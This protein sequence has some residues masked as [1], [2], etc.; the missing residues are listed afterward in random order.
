MSISVSI[1]ILVLGHFNVEHN[2]LL[3]FSISGGSVQIELGELCI[4]WKR[5]FQNLTVIVHKAT[6]SA[7]TPLATHNGFYTQYENVLNM[8]QK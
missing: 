2:I 3:V 6:Q 7:V 1:W 8:K 5:Q 4:Y